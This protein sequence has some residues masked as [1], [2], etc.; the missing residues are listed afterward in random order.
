M[1]S[2]MAAA[3]FPIFPH[4]HSEQNLWGRGSPSS[5]AGS[6][7]QMDRSH[8]S[9]NFPPLQAFLLIF[10]EFSPS[11]DSPPERFRSPKQEKTFTL[12]RSSHSR[13]HPGRENLLFLEPL[14]EC[15]EL[16]KDTAAV[17]VPPLDRGASN[18]TDHA[19]PSPGTAD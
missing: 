2:F 17:K 6:D 16:R 5:A 7:W 12:Q 10:P 18:R 8:S 14:M 13:T 11:F 3:S 4:L 1:L 15:H 9:I 19:P